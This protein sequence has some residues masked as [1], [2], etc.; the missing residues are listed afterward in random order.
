MSPRRDLAQAWGH[1]DCK[2]RGGKRHPTQRE[3]R[4]DRPHSQWASAQ[5]ALGQGT[6]RETRRGRMWYK[7]SARP[8]DV[9]S[10]SIYTPNLG[11][12]KYTRQPLTDLNGNLDSWRLPH[13]HQWIDIHTESQE[14]NNSLKWS[15]RP[16]HLRE[17]WDHSTAKQQNTQ[18]PQG[19]V[20]H[21]Q[22]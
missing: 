18:S 21:S 8:E 16:A 10:V 9:T 13:L 15:I 17:I 19:H 20:E 14:G 1:K 6:R 12:L 3:R 22:G 7:G 2:R 5:Q 11:V 4:Q